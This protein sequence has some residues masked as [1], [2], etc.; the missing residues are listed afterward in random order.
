[1]AKGNS[2]HPWGHRTEVWN[3]FITFMSSGGDKV[4]NY[5]LNSYFQA[6]GIPVTPEVENCGATVWDLI[7]RVL[8]EYNYLST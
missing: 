2:C 4:G 5:E 6:E 3:D 7:I 8:E 1:M